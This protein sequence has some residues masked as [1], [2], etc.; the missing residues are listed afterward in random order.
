MQAR[1]FLISRQ[2]FIVCLALGAIL[3]VGAVL[4]FHDVERRTLN[5]PEAYT[6]GIDLPWNLSNPNPRFTLWQTLAG[7]IAGEPHPPGYYIVMLGWTKL[8]G[9]SIFSLRLPSVLFGEAAIF[10]IYVLATYTDDSLTGL[11]AAAMLAANGRH[12]YWSQTARMYS[13]ACFLGLSSTV[14]L[15]LNLKTAGRRRIYRALYFVFTLAG[16]ATH[17]Y[18]WAIFAAQATW[19]WATSIRKYSSPPRLLRLQILLCILASPLLAIAAYQSSTATRPTTLIPWEGVLRFLQFGSLFETDPLV[20]STS[21]LDGLVGILAILVSALL[22]VNSVRGKAKNR[23]SESSTELDVESSQASGMAVTVVVALLTAL[24]ILG[25]AY[26]ANTILPARSTWSVIAAS[27]IPVA[28]S[29]IYFFI[30]RHWTRLR[31]WLSVLAKP[32]SVQSLNFVLAVLPM[33]II[34]GV[35]LFNPI[36]IERGT[37][38]F[39]PYLLIVLSSGL[40]NLLYRDKRW[41]A[42]VVIVVA[43][44]CLSISQSEARIPY[45]DYKSLAEQWAPQID[46]SDLILV[47]G[48]GHPADWLVAPIFYYLN[49]RHYHFVGRNFSQEIENHPRSRVWVLSFPEIPTEREVVDALKNYNLR[50]RLDAQNI[51]AQLYVTKA[52]AIEVTRRGRKVTLLH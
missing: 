11:L 39:A 32:L 10:L 16:L 23:R 33:T 48:R 19:T 30:A 31:G 47:H 41:V 8:F 13:M 28:L 52:P 20:N 27:M 43:V 22:F 21:F 1:V 51:F 38:L 26:I 49:A 50:E 15:I 4:R 46:D 5:H 40:A 45:N 25:F 2:K 34:A 44:H 3:T 42:V 17:V 6:P 12:V 9:S 7:S 35:S 37:M 24:A 29:L 14:L 36:F 18:F